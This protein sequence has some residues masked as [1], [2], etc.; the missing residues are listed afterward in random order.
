M[1]PTGHGEFRLVFTRRLPPARCQDLLPAIQGVLDLLRAEDRELFRLSGYS[2]SMQ[3]TPVWE[4][5]V[6]RA[7]KFLATSQIEWNF[8]R[9]PSEPTHEVSFFNDHE[10]ARMTVVRAAFYL[11]GQECTAP[12][13]EVVVRIGAGAAE[14]G[15]VDRLFKGLVA[16]LTPDAGR[17]ESPEGAIL[18]ELTGRP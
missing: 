3:R 6:S 9:Q 12:G 13:V 16:A 10:D 8:G 17:L 2:P 15:R 1:A 5:D 18:R 14:P 7:D 4:N 11:E